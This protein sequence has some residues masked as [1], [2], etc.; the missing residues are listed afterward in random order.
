MMKGIQVTVKLWV[1]HSIIFFLSCW[2]IRI[3][4][5]HRPKCSKVWLLPII[6]GYPIHKS[7]DH[8]FF[9][10][11]I[12]VFPGG[13]TSNEYIVL[14]RYVSVIGYFIEFTIGQK[15]IHSMKTIIG[16]IKKN[17]SKLMML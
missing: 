10:H 4:S 14:A 17:I 11:P 7:I 16:R 13:S 12:Q 15:F 3:M 8:A 9:V 6:N 2:K 1:V 5:L